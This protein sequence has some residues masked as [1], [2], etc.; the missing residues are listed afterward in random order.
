MSSF[1]HEIDIFGKEPELYYRGRKKKST[2]IGRIF[3]LLYII[4]YLSIFIYE[5]IVMIKREEI[6]YIST[7]DYSNKSPRVFLT[8]DN[9]YSGFGLL[10]PTGEPMFDESIYH[11]KA[12]LWNRKRLNGLYKWEKIDLELEKC[13]LQKF[14]YNK[15]MYCFKRLNVSLETSEINDFYSY[16]EIQIFPCRGVNCKPELFLNFFLKKTNFIF[17]IEDIYLTPQ[18]YKSPVQHKKRSIIT[19]IFSTLFEETYLKFQEIII[20]TEKDIF[21][22]GSSNIKKEEF[23]KYE[24]VLTYSSPIIDDIY[25]S[26]NPFCIGSITLEISEN[27]FIIQRSSTKFVDVLADVG[28]IM[29]V[30]LTGFDLILSVIIDLLY[31]KS[32]VNDLFQFDLDK[33]LII[34]K[35]NKNNIIKENNS[36]KTNFV[37]PL[38]INEQNNANK[39]INKKNE[40][41]N[42]NK[43][44]KDIFSS[45]SSDED[46]W[47]KFR[48]YNIN[49]KKKNKINN[50]EPQIEK[51]ENIDENKINI[52]IME[53][54]EKKNIVNKIEVNKTFQYLYFWFC[55]KRNDMQNVLLE[56]GLHIIFQNLDIVNLFR[57]VCI[58][59]GE[60]IL[61]K[62]NK[63][64][65]SRRSVIKLNGIINK[66]NNS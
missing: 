57:K 64:E 32:L 15:D 10:S 31:E 21:G 56:E 63:I 4:I 49:L 53:T 36:K 27:S 16:I 43:L 42:R 41:S 52:E 33:K 29:K 51:K 55:K 2:L 25:N 28:G 30:I 47:K 24:S 22:F 40:S 48:I 54:N 66:S 19:P 6:S 46:I 50:M 9:F 26:T 12:T 61:L 1:L 65:M 38:L 5:L 37:H 11:L 18:F 8:N 39:T 34:I 62:K 17:I 60:Q 45:S 23:L 3:T 44:I 58:D 13:K 7:V 59:E 35:S 14:E 20:Q